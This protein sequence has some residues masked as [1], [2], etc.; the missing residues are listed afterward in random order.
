[1]KHSLSLH[2]P[3]WFAG[4]IV[5]IVVCMN[6]EAR[7]YGESVT[8]RQARDAGVI[9]EILGDTPS[10]RE[11]VEKGV[12]LFRNTCVFLIRF[13]SDVEKATAN[14]KRVLYLSP[15]AKDRGWGEVVEVE[16]KV[17]LRPEHHQELIDWSAFGHT[18]HYRIGAGKQPGIE[19]AKGPAS[20]LCSIPAE[21]EGWKTSWKPNWKPIP[22]AASLGLSNEPQ[23]F[24]SIPE[25]NKVQDEPDRPV[26]PTRKL[27]VELRFNVKISREA[28][29]VEGKTNLPNG[30][31]L[32]IA[33]NAKGEE[34]PYAL[35]DSIV[36]AS[37]FGV[38]IKKWIG[39]NPLPLGDY[40]AEVGIMVPSEQP[41]E[42]M[43]IIGNKGQ[44]LTGRFVTTSSN[45]LGDGKHK[46]V[47]VR[48]R[49]I[50]TI[51][52]PSKL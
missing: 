38:R 44:N 7:N 35:E 33:V 49:F 39:G 2:L 40:V 5:L 30:T 31:K 10:Q 13:W 23:N 25:E 50:T 52:I 45:F 4:I 43:A 36:E 27:S 24:K 26:K 41:E 6:C 28:V 3:C 47:S 51:P 17:K 8:D 48:K 37:R 46:D 29:T 14:L 15:S 18:L 11:K 32:V 22:Q 19:A 16:V 9:I 21:K 20:K 12:A 34:E 1:M 42:V